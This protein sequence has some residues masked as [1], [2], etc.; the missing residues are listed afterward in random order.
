MTVYQ[1]VRCPYVRL[2]ICAFVRLPVCP[3]VYLDLQFRVG[4]QDAAEDAEGVRNRSRGT[5][6]KL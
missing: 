1:S 3:S 5:S 2:T 4:D 6:S